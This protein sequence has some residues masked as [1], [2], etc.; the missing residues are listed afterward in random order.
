LSGPDR[1]ISGKMRQKDGR[2]NAP[3]TRITV[4]DQEYVWS[5]RHGFLVHGKGL[6]V[7]SV[8]VALEPGRTRELIINFTFH[9]EPHAKD[10]SEGRMAEALLSAI[11]GAIEDGWNPESRGR[12]YKF[13]V[14]GR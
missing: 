6:K 9:L 4:D 11:R 1:L 14:E 10:P 13:D 2:Q 8:S 7:V 3:G 5:Y 12:A